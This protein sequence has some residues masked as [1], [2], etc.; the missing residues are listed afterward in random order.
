MKNKTIKLND[1]KP[2]D[3]IYKMMHDTLEE[4][5]ELYPET[6]T[7]LLIGILDLMKNEIKMS[8]AE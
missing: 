5:S 7:A 2:E 8:C 3:I 4:I 6:P 1:K